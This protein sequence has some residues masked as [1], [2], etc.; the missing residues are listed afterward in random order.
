MTFKLITAIRFHQ[1]TDKMVLR[2]RE[3][4]T[5]VRT[6]DSG[7]LEDELRDNLSDLRVLVAK[8]YCVILT[9]KLILVSV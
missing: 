6:A 9:G 5:K 1:V 2:N 3:L 4:D 8:E 7:I